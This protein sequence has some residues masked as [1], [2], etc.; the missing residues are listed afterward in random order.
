MAD[1]ARWLDAL[2]ADG[3]ER[4]LLASLMDRYQRM[5]QR[6]YLTASHFLDL[7][8]R[9]WPSG[10]FP[11]PGGR[12]S[13]SGAGM[14]RPSAKWRCST[15]P[16][17]TREEACR[18]LPAAV[19]RVQRAGLTPLSHRDYLGALLSTGVRREMVGDILVEEDGAD[20]L[21]CEELA[22]YVLG[23]LQ[24]AGRQRLEGRQVP[25]DQ[26]RQ[27]EQKFALLRDTVPALR[28]DCIV[29]R[30]VLPLPGGE[31]AGRLRRP[32]AGQPASGGKGR[33][34]GQPRRSDHPP[35]PGPHPA[36][37]RRRAKPQGTDVCRDQKMDVVSSFRQ[38]V[39]AGCAILERRN[40]SPRCQERDG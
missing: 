5:D 15:R 32:G 6:Q 1:K 40:R 4:V 28:L 27:I 34:P 14:S 16:Y 13:C 2:A 26:L 25:L 7:V 20:I 23:Q 35:R 3:E 22:E 8:S 38:T 17:L 37:K 30:R 11:S 33:R 9:R 21:L 36:G 24:R 31:P 18:Q 39:A 12:G 10:P 29:R 19:I